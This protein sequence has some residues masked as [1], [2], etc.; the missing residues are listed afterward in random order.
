MTDHAPSVPTS[1][2]PASDEGFAGEGWERVARLAELGVLSA[3]LLHEMRQPLFAIKGMAQLAQYR[4]GTLDRDGLQELLVHVRHIEDLLD[5]YAG[6]GRLEEPSAVFDLGDVVRQAA[7]MLA[8]RGRQLG[9][10]LKLFTSDRPHRVRGRPMAAR[11][12]A[13]N[14]LQNAMDA[15]ELV[16]ESRR[17][18]VQLSHEGAHV[19]LIVRD[20]GPGIPEELRSRMFE[21]FVTTKPV[22]RGTGLGL[23]IARSLVTEAGGQLELKFP[24]EGGTIA[25][26]C[27]PGA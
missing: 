13:V 20:T 9:A 3:S 8:H 17:I 2:P 27:L 4:E 15:V 5:H 16:S 11:Q 18:H 7:A 6:F 19:R 10:E 23:F 12:V 21:P 24:E 26:V 22:G 1:W 14:L 25:Q